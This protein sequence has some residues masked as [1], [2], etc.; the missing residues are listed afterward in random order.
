[1]NLQ[2]KIQNIRKN[3]FYRFKYDPTMLVSRTVKKIMSVLKLSY[4]AL[5][6]ERLTDTQ[7]KEIL[8]AM[9]LL[10]AEFEVVKEKAQS[11]YVHLKSET[12]K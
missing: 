7:K 5:N 3:S 1:M 11:K 9:V 10:I 12:N 4:K 6:K 2:E 8:E